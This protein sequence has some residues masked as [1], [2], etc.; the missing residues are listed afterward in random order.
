MQRDQLPVKNSSRSAI[1]LNCLGLSQVKS[2]LCPYCLT[3]PCWCQTLLLLFDMY[4]LILVTFS[5][6]TLDTIG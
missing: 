1:G 3:C 5:L 2:P 4:P 6:V